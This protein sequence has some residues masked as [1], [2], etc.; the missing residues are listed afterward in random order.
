MLKAIK[1]SYVSLFKV[2]KVDKD[3]G[4]VYYEDVFTK[5]KYRI[6]DVAMSSTVK[7]SKKREIYI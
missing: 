7:V 6:I 3:N 4:Y 1:N 2:V 5:R